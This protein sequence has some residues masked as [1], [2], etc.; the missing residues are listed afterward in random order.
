M[1]DGRT[2]ESPRAGGADH[3]DESQRPGWAD[4]TDESRRPDGTDRNATFEEDP[5][6]ATVDWEEEYAAGTLPEGLEPKVRARLGPLADLLE[7]AGKDARQELID[8]E[9]NRVAVPKA[10]VD[11]LAQANRRLQARVADQTRMLESQKADLEDKTRRLEAANR[12]KDL[13]LSRTGH[14]IRNH[15]G[16]VLAHA[17]LAWAAGTGGASEQ[18][19]AIEDTCQHLLEL[20]DTL[21]DQ[22]ALA[23]GSYSVRPITFS[24]EELVCSVGGELAEGT[25]RSKQ[26][27]L[28]QA[29]PAVVHAV[30]ADPRRLTQ[31]LHNFIEN[32]SKF[33]QPGTTIEVTIEARGETV[34]VEVLDEGPGIPIHMLP[35]LFD[36]LADIGNRPTGGEASSGLGLTVVADIIRRHGGEVW[37]RNRASGG[38]AFGFALPAVTDQGEEPITWSLQ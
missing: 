31:V 12:A 5:L 35:H 9:G 32:A 38:A 17:T 19:E 27:E 18:L 14:D 36:P 34:V 29:P 1:Q 30:H 37:G 15:V 4:R 24:L 10:I 16:S 7:R 11:H 13:L 3:T 6:D 33:S 25:L 8:R 26:Q 22:A 2:D 20:L 21:V 28:V 23:S